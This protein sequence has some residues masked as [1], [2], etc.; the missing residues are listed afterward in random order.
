MPEAIT[1]WLAMFVSALTLI[2]L[3]GAGAMFT[4]RRVLWPAFKRGVTDA[5][6]PL[7][8]ELQGIRALAEQTAG[9]LSVYQLRMDEERTLVAERAVVRA[10]EIDEKLGSV[11]RDLSDIKGSQSS[12]HGRLGA[13]EARQSRDTQKVIETVEAAAANGEAKP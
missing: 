4:W 8:E 3:L 10:G 2:G 1:P 5:V 12:I 13:L 9:D 6:A 11:A 7:L